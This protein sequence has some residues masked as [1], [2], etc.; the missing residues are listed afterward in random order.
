VDSGGEWVL[1]DMTGWRAVE[2]VREFKDEKG[3]VESGIR[4]WE[5]LETGGSR[6]VESNIESS[7]VRVVWETG[8]DGKGW[9]ALESGGAGVV[10]HNVER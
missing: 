1:R 3:A 9:S 10:Q 5:W 8:M 4:K 7:C 2:N 6:V